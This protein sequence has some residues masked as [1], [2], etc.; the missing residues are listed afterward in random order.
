MLGAEPKADVV[1]LFAPN[2]LVLPKTGFAV[3]LD[4]CPRTFVPVDEVLA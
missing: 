3:E 1:G 2:A 4:C